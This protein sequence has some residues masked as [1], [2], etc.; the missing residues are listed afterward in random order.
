MDG[1]ILQTD[2]F[3]LFRRTDRQALLRRIAAAGDIL[4]LCDSDGGGRQIR[5]YLSSILPPEHVHHLFI[6]QVAGK[7]RRK[8]TAGAAGTLGVE[9]MDRETLRRLL[10][11]FALPRSDADSPRPRGRAVTKTDF[12]NDGLSGAPD[13]AARRAALAQAYRFPPDMTANALLEALN[14]ITDYDGYSAAVEELFGD[15]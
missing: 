2:G 8:K 11:P 1:L 7:E 4:V 10:A 3:A 13:A 14:I 9:G 12:Y 15:E 6:P 5:R